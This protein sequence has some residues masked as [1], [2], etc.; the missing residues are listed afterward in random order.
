M[1]TKTLVSIHTAAQNLRFL[2]VAGK[3]ML[4]TEEFGGSG[5]GGGNQQT[6]QLKR[7]LETTQEDLYKM[8][9]VNILC[10]DESL[11]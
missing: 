10:L 6:K 2:Q 11:N 5:N 1:I 8:E 7:Q 3:G 9:K 4:K